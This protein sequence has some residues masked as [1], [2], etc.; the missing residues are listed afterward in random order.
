MAEGLCGGSRS[1][2]AAYQ[3]T[4]ATGESSSKAGTSSG[5]HT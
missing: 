3:A 4:G 2:V 5:T 1:L